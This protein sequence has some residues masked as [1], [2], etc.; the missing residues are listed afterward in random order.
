[1]KIML[2]LAIGVII[3]SPAFAGDMLKGEPFYSGIYEGKPIELDPFAFQ[4]NV[5]AGFKHSLS[6]YFSSREIRE[7]ETE[8]TQFQQTSQVSEV[9][10]SGSIEFFDGGVEADE[11]ILEKR[12]A[13]EREFV[14]FG[15]TT[16]IEGTVETYGTRVI[17]ENNISI[18]Y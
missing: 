7:V 15:N 2:G 14:T 11:F 18:D 16:F 8:E 1:M 6:P 17:F 4:P 13:R 10:N 9:T 3:A 5:R 12:F